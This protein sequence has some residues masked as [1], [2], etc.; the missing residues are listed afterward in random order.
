[1]ARSKDRKMFQFKCMG[2][3][4]LFYLHAQR[5]HT[6]VVS[7]CPVCGSKPVKLTGRSYPCVDEEKTVDLQ[8]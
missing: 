7:H 6:W 3:G 2:E 1:M 5:G 8:V 4:T